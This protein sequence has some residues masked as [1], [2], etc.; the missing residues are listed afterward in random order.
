MRIKKEHGGK[1][2]AQFLY[3]SVGAEIKKI[4]KFLFSAQPKGGII[5][6][7]G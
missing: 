2:R 1:L 4:I 7:S 5:C 6:L 3:S